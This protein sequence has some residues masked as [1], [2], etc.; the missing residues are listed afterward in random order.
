MAGELDDTRRFRA[1]MALGGIA[2]AAGDFEASIGPFEAA[3][4]LAPYEPTALYALGSSLTRVGKTERARQCLERSALLARQNV[5]LSDMIRKL[6]T[7]PDA[8]AT[9]RVE[10]ATILW[11]QNK[12][13][14]AAG[15]M[16][17]ALRHD[18]TLRAAHEMLADF[19]QETGRAEL[20]QAHRDALEAGAELDRLRGLGGPPASGAPSRLEL[21]DR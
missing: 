14:D 13:E 10:V 6:L 4:K 18:P 20:A 15:W 7:T 3:V 17:S 11:D 9:L 16:S 8:E 5:R 1:W 21:P 12:K 19:Y 2:S